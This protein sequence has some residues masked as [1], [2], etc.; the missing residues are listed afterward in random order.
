[1][2]NKWKWSAQLGVVLLCALG[3]K[4]F[5]S[6]AS[7]DELRWI[8]AP[9]TWLVELASGQS[10]NF[11]AH[12]GYMSS[13]HSFLIAASCAGVNFLIAAFLMLALKRLWEGRFE[14]IGRALVPISLLV[15]YAT[16]IVTNTVRICVALRLKALQHEITWLSPGQLHRAEGILIYFA[17][18]FLL[19]F[20]TERERK[21]RNLLRQS[22]VPM[23]FYYAT[24]L[25][26]PLVNGAYKR[27][28]EFWQHTIF[29]LLL[30]LLLMIPVSLV[31][32]L[33]RWD[34]HAA[35][36]LCRSVLSFTPGFSLRR[37]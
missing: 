6:T 1:M 22:L 37:R 18:L 20:L 23:A 12:S 25:G 8:L 21:G 13:D 3:L 30:P 14:T 5:Y 33:M 29:V 19:Y 34:A 9:T 11:E 16:T 10:F 31:R 35:M 15:A 27:G 7:P 28:L 4:A 17:F 24:T 32:Y 26:L 2:N 36:K